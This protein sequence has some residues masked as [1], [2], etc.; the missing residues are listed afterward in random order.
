MIEVTHEKGDRFRVSVRGHRLVTDQ[1]IDAGGGD[2][3]PTPTELFVAGL[4]ACVAFYGGRF[5]RRH[6]DG[7]VSVTCTYD[8]SEDRPARVT[9]IR[10]LVDV[11]TALRSD[12]RDGLRRAI[13][14]CTVH[15]SLR[16]PPDVRISVRD[17]V[18]AA[19][20]E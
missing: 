17:A 5:L 18:P 3:G 8:M 11:P 20:A 2:A 16:T 15:N 19:A 1:P 6:T 9:A 4:A 7:S 10:I 14:H 12:V 13:E